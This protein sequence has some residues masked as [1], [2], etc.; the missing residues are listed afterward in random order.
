MESCDCQLRPTHAG[1]RYSTAEEIAN[2][3]T[4]GLGAALSIAAIALLATFAGLNG[5]AWHVVSVSLF[6]ATLFILYLSSTLYHGLRPPRAKN[7]FMVFD[8]AAIFLLIAGTYTPFTLVTLRGPW[9]WTLF[10][11]TWGVAIF[12]VVFSALSAG[13]HRWASLAMYLG[14]GWIVLVAIKPLV[15]SLS[16]GGLMWMGLGGLCYTAGVIF[17]VGR[18]IPFNHAIWHL[19]VLAGSICHF[20]AV[21]WYVVP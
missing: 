7:V 20:F 8:H 2:A 4:H 18:R 5:D 16:A 1:R 10:G 13:R 14:L 17:Y 15:E 21:F 19:F 3:V 6:G 11:L 9:G 12:G